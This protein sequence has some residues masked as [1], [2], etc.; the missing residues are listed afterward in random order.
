MNLLVLDTATDRCA[1]ACSVAGRIVENTRS[2]PRMH[3]EYLLQMLEELL[4]QAGIGPQEL[5][6]IGFAAGPGSFTGIRISAAVTQAL[7][8]GA[9]A[10]VVPLS[11]SA[12]LARAARRAGVA[13]AA[14]G[15]QTVL[16]SRRNFAYLASYS[17]DLRVVADDVLFADAALTEQPLPTGWVRVMDASAQAAAEVGAAPVEVSV[18]D[19][20]ALTE[21]QLAAGGG[22]PPEGA[23]PRY[24]EGDTPWQPR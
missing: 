8:I 14:A 1:L 6:A 12:L 17:E 15:V 16:R 2:I 24:V 19:L 9:Q 13:K 7:A 21:T 3:N 5:T 18:A 23:Q 10:V 20:L 4:A 11:S 22:L